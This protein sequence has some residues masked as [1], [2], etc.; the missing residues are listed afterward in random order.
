VAL[1]DGIVGKRLLRRRCDM[2][3]V[4]TDRA[5]DHDTTQSTA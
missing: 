5:M 3:S 4:G 2:L 1:A